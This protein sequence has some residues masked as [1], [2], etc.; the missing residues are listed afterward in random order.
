MKVNHTAARRIHNSEVAF[1]LEL[2]AANDESFS[3]DETSMT[4]GT[5][6]FAGPLP[7]A[8]IKA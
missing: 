3:V 2:L 5:P 7:Q 1:F 6:Y 8:V 4:L